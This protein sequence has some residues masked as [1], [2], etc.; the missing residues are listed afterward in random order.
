MINTFVSVLVSHHYN[1][2]QGYLDQ[3]LKSVLASVGVKYDVTVVADTENA[4]VVPTGVTLVHNKDLNTASKKVNWASKHAKGT[5]L[6]WLSDDVMISK[7]L[8][9]T[10]SDTATKANAIVNAYSNNDVGSYYLALPTLKAHGAP[11]LPLK[12]QMDLSYVSGYEQC[13]IDYPHSESILITVPW[14]PFYCTMMTKS[15]FEQVGDLDERL[16]SRH[17]DEDYCLRANHK[18]IRTLVNFG[19]FAL[20]FGG[21]TLDRSVTMIE[22]DECTRMFT[23]KWGLQRG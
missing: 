16:D 2:N 14:I 19:V 22:R 15:T 13:V 21:K 3:C 7:H 5:H 6:L 10:L 17:N 18:G 4:P 20:H 1:D 9:A 11:P 8:L 23:E 12:H